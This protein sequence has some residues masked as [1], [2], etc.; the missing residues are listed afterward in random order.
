[1]KQGITHEDKKEQKTSGY[2]QVKY[3]NFVEK[4]SGGRFNL[5]FPPRQ[6]IS[7]KLGFMLD[8]AR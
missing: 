8:I 5:E 3:A 7:R 6:L 2:F 4:A 1:M